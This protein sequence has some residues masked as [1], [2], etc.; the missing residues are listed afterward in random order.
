M[1]NLMAFLN[2]HS[3][4]LPEEARSEVNKIKT[5]HDKQMIQKGMIDQIHKEKPS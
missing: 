2:S 4:K 1:F 3:D 5:E